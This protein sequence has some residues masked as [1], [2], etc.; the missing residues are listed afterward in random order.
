MDFIDFA[1]AHGLRIRSLVVGK[2]VRV[3]TDEH[4]KKR[5]GAYKY[6][7]D[8]GFVQNWATQVDASVWHPERPDDIRINPDRV[9]QIQRE[10]EA[11]LRRDR[12]AAAQKAQWIVSQA[13]PSTHPYL[14]RK[15]F[16]DEKG[17]VWDELL[18]VPMRVNGVVGCQLV[19]PDGVKKFLKGQVTN[20]ATFVMGQGPA[21]LCEGYAT[22]L[23][24]RAA[25]S[26]AKVKRSV[27]VCFSAHNMLKVSASHKDAIVVADNDESMTGEN[28]ARQIGLP[29]WMSTV[30]GE[31]F[32]DAHRRMGLFKISQELKKLAIIRR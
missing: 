3:S 29:Y 18:V 14:E 15:G 16:P 5:N 11:Q 21:V 23:S 31:D 25:L 20:M 8:V 17:L 9:A 10:Q 32:N 6:M 26:A 1:R 22:G 12:Q 24:V 27:V 13:K 7:G 4:P 28:T 30:K 2:W 19:S